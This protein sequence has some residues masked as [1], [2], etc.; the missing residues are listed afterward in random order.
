M[1]ER[2]TAADRAAE[3]RRTTV[4]VMVGAVVLSAVLFLIA[5]AV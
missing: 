5:L 2:L 3:H 4:W 1:T